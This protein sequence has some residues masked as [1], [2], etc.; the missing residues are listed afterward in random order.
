MIHHR[1][2]DPERLTRSEIQAIVDQGQ[3]PTVQF[4]KPIY[5]RPFLENL[6]SL[7]VEFGSDLEVRFFGFYGRAFDASVLASLPNVR[8]LAV[9]CLTRI[10]QEDW[11]YKLSSLERL[12]FGVFEFARNDFLAGLPLENLK[13]LSVSETKNRKLDLGV[14]HRCENLTDLFVHG[15]TKNIEAL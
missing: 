7:C 14:L 8:R 1:I 15:H 9:D 10:E 4:S 2:T 6:N 5:D 13:Q 11:L 12:S 3:S